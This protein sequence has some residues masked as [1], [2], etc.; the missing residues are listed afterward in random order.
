MPSS[1]AS[2][3]VLPTGERKRRPFSLGEKVDAR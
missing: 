1:G 2:R 3:R